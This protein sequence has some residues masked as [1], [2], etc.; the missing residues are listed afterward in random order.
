MS[1]SFLQVPLGSKVP[2][3]FIE[4]DTTKSQQGVSIKPYNALLIGQKLADGTKAE[5]LIDKI[6][7]GSQAREFYGKGSMLFHMA[8][9]FIGENN[10]LNELNC[11]SLVDD[12]GAVKAAGT[13]EILTAPTGD[14]TLSLMLAGRRYR[15]AVLDADTEEDI[16]DK[17]V[18]EVTADEDRLVDVVKNGSNADL[19]DITA[20]NAGVVGNDLDIRENF[21][22]GEELPAGITSTIVAM[23]GGTANPDIT[24]VIV[25]MGETQ[26]DIIVMP[27]SD[28]ANLLLMKTELQDR[29][30]PI[31]QNDGH[32]FICR[33]ESFASHSTFLDGRNNEQE[34][35]KNIAGPTPTFQWASNLGA[36]VAASA[37]GDPAKP[38]QTLPLTQVLAPLE[39]ELF[40]FGERDQIL[41]AGGSTFFVD[42]GG[43]VRIER[44]RTTRVENEFGALDE[45]LADLNPK[46]TVS[47]IRFD[48]RN[49]MLT[50][51]P[52]HKLADDGTR[53]G[54]GQAIITP[55]IGKSE[56]VARFELWEELGLV[57]GFEQFKR[58]LVVERNAQ[59]VTRLDFL[60]SPD[61][62]NQ[63]RVTG[64][65][66]GF[67]L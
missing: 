33:K 12:G 42:S 5:K 3:V 21:F 62:V 58:D 26:F 29:W 52:R 55:K 65:Q 23:T 8:E 24:D 59:D 44:L 53:F 9:V 63:L 60:L 57:E 37:Q 20:R 54:P 38:F 41:K 67:L 2:G 13:Y 61:L 56:A 22:D 15:V 66:I 48:F 17:L 51:Y 35:V 6:T 27:Y 47:F 46:L 1:I 16:I 34:T 19:L 64:V 7:S 18:T 45:A 14:G 28:A 11:I 4:F 36:L 39:S 32:L 10:N 43:A 40:D 50:K 30:G 31:R 25:A 49:L